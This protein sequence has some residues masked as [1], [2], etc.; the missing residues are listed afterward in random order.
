MTVSGFHLFM[1]A[2]GS[3]ALPLRIRTTVSLTEDDFMAG[4]E[5]SYGKA[6][7]KS[8]SR[9]SSKK[10]HDFDGR[11]SAGNLS[12]GMSAKTA[13]GSKVSTHQIS[14]G[15]QTSF[16]RFLRFVCKI[17]FCYLFQTSNLRFRS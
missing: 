7:R 9:R 13:K 8:M 10:H 1:V 2:I 16:I 11:H 4:E 6:G 12:G 5:N 3:K 14:S 15:P 17:T